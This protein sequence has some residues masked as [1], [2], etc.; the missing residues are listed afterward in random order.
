MATERP[1]PV[2]YIPDDCAMSVIRFDGETGGDYTLFYCDKD[3]VVDHIYVTAK[4]ATY[5]GSSSSSE[6]VGGDSIGGPG[7]PKVRVGFDADPGTVDA[8]STIVGTQAEVTDGAVVAL[9]VEANTNV[10]PS[11]NYLNIEFIGT[12]TDCVVQVRWR[13]KKR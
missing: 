8:G 13:S 2:Q 5:S 10:I 11:G 7:I 12:V 3:I 1:I 6:V 4:T 9:T